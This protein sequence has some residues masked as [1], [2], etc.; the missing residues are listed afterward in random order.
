MWWPVELMVTNMLIAAM[1]KLLR[2]KTSHSYNSQ[3]VSFLSFGTSIAL[4]CFFC[5]GTKRSKAAADVVAT[6]ECTEHVSDKEKHPK[7]KRR[8][9]TATNM[10]TIC[11]I[12]AIIIVN[13]FCLCIVWKASWTMKGI[14][15]GRWPNRIRVPL[16]QKGKLG[17]TLIVKELPAEV[18]KDEN[19][20]G[21]IQKVTGAATCKWTKGGHLQ[22][23]FKTHEDVPAAKGKKKMLHICIGY[24][25]TS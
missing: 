7:K 9:A 8:T 14:P 6:D 17:R 10:G 11:S 20:C 5:I 18:C 19:L 4:T 16:Q 23:D 24:Y 13:C 25:C 2:K 21:E 22:L 15:L 12:F 3:R 1:M